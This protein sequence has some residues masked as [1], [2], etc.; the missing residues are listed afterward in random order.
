VAKPPV[1]GVSDGTLEPGT[2]NPL[3]GIVVAGEISMDGVSKRV[4]DWS[5]D[6]VA[7]SKREIS[8]TGEHST[9][10]SWCNPVSSTIC[11]AIINYKTA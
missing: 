9:C 8:R 10:R 11:F 6:D 4:K 2:G 5:Q 3:N 1:V 7:K